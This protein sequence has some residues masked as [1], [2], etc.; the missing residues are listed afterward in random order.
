MVTASATLTPNKS[1][2]I[3]A[4]AELFLPKLGW[5]RYRN[6]REVLGAVRNVT[7]SRS[8]SKWY[9]SI[10]TQREVGQPVPTATTAIGID[11]GIACFAT[12]SD[13]SHIALLNSFKTKKLLNLRF[14]YRHRASHR[15]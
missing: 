12:F 8:G 14:G 5:I 2:S 3:K 1:S 4:I 13:G 7:V 9:I 10:Q 6:S 11:L 15:Q